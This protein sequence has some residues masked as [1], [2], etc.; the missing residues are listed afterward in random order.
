LN[1]YLTVVYVIYCLSV[2]ILQR[3][4]VLFHKQMRSTIVLSYLQ[5]GLLIPITIL[6]DEVF[7]Y[8]YR[9]DERTFLEHLSS[10]PVI[11]GDSIAQAFV[12]CI[13][14]CRSLIVLFLWLMYCLSVL[15]F[16]VFSCTCLGRRVRKELS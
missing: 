15:R 6:P 2:Y 11:W 13:M 5:C 10:P 12:F 1:N 7:I 14:I 9:L 8:R 16:M 3:I 4:P